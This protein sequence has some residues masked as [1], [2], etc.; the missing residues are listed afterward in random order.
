[1][2]LRGWLPRDELAE[3]YA[4]AAGFIHVGEEDFGITMVEALAAG[5]PVVAARPRRRARHRAP[6]RR[7]GVLVVRPRAGAIVAGCGELAERDW[8]P[9]ALR[10]SAARF[11]ERRFRERLGAVLRAHGAR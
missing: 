2:E 3:L 4:S 8:D 7:D 6:G 9:A 11:S 1:M 5:T 10:R